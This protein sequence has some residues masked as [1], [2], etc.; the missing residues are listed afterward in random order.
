MTYLC[1]YNWYCNHI[2]Q[3]KNWS[4]VSNFACCNTLY[5]FRQC[6]KDPVTGFNYLSGEVNFWFSRVKSNL[7]DRKW[8]SCSHYQITRI[9]RFHNV[10]C[11][12]MV[13]ENTNTSSGSLCKIFFLTSSL[14]HFFFQA[15]SLA[16]YF[17]VFYPLDF[18]YCQSL[19]DLTSSLL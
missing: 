10:F 3:K 15:P 1:L 11:I 8:K 2:L 18:S 12:K 14:Y 7:A 13:V 16:W 17:F 19:T 5:I 9:L 6:H 4:Q